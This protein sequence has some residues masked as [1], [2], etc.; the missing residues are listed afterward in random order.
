[1]VRK[2]RPS[3]PRATRGISTG[4]NALAAS[5][6]LGMGAS[7]SV[8]AC[9]T[10]GELVF[11]GSAVTSIE[12]VTI[13]LENNGGRP[14]KFALRGNSSKPAGVLRVVECSVTPLDMAVE[15]TTPG[16]YSSASPGE[17][18]PLVSFYRKSMDMLTP[19][20]SAP[21]AEQPMSPEQQ[22]GVDLVS[23]PVFDVSG[24]E[25]GRVYTA[26]NPGDGKT[27]LP[28]ESAH[29][30]T[31]EADDTLRL[32]QAV[33]TDGAHFNLIKRGKHKGQQRVYVWTTADID[34]V[35]WVRHH[36]CR[37]YLLKIAVYR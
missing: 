34:C 32:K 12:Q 20:K 29:P 18:R 26:R 11:V 24:R 28:S 22:V 30:Q 13:A 33:L 23:N 27:T 9:P 25:T 8:S 15:V 17:G 36:V 19:Q 31:K 16:N 3:Q 21:A 37:A 5:I 4:R 6:R 1:M 35:C 14:I 7:N 10:T 2:A